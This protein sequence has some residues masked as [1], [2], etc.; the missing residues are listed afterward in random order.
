MNDAIIFLI[1]TMYLP[2]CVFALVHQDEILE[3][4]AQFICDLI[5]K[6]NERKS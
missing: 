4:P 3:K 6:Y 2:L 5:D 1:I